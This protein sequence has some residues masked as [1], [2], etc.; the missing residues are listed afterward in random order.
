MEFI[1]TC[2]WIGAPS[3]FSLVSFLTVLQSQACYAASVVHRLTVSIHP[4]VVCSVPSF[5]SEWHHFW[6]F[7]ILYELLCFYLEKFLKLFQRHRIWL[8]ALRVSESFLLLHR[9]THAYRLHH[10]KLPR[11]MREMKKYHLA[12]HYKNFELGYGVTS[13]PLFVYVELSWKAC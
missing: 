12:H 1:I 2:L 5:S 10:T 7:H 9:L 8:H 11:Y 3:L 6:G 13:E 4:I